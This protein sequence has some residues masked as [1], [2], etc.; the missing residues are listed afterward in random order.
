MTL[1]FYHFSAIVTIIGLVSFVIVALYLQRRRRSPKAVNL[2]VVDGSN[3][4]HWK[5]NTPKFETLRQVLKE[6]KGRG[7]V[8]GVVF[9]ANVG[10]KLMGRYLHDR[11]LA[12]LLALPVDR[13]MVVPKGQP[14][15]WTV[16]LA[17][18]DY[19]A[20]VVTNDQFR[21]WLDEFPEARRD[22]YLIAGG[23]RKG[24]LWLDVDRAQSA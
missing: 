8:P 15:D 2:V 7:F 10:Y 14:A 24:K 18:R 11:E 21:D 5:D 4:M 19:D 22:G 17:A 13:V 3:V 16:L 12:K 6:L 9:D 20:R 23:Y 1:S